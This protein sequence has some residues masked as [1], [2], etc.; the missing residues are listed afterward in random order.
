MRGEDRKQS[1]MFSYVSPEQRVPQDHPLR[2]IR[3]MVDEALKALWPGN[4]A[5]PLLAQLATFISL[6]TTNTKPWLS[7]P[8][9]AMM[10]DQRCDRIERPSRSCYEKEQPKIGSYKDK[11][12]SI[13]VA[14]IWSQVCPSRTLPPDFGVLPPHCLKKNGIPAT[15]HCFFISRTHSGLIGRWRGPLS[16]P[17]ITHWIPSS[18]RFAIGPRRGSMERKRTAAG[19]LCR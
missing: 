10:W 12:K 11:V 15:A 14:G 9:R 18:G 1:G 3:A 13:A 17:T 7:N 2:T 8:V 5:S 4:G 19:T 16:P 6:K